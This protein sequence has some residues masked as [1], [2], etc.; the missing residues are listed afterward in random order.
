MDS[1]SSLAE[2]FNTSQ[3]GV[4]FTDIAPDLDTGID[5]ERIE[6]RRNEAFDEIKA[7]PTFSFEDIGDVPL[8]PRGSP[9]VAV[10]DYDN[11]G[12][13]GDS[14]SLQVPKSAFINTLCQSDLGR[15][16]RSL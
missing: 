10:F 4:T 9:G 13:N 15:F 8:F 16:T 2:D 11:D 3:D 14:P 6:S 5:Y 12:N 7:Q 1:N